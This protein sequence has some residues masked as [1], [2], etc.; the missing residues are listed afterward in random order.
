MLKEAITAIEMLATSHTRAPFVQSPGG[1]EFIFDDSENRYIEIKRPPVGMLVSGSLSSLGD[2]LAANIDKLETKDL[3]LHVAGPG[4][5]DL[6]GPLNEYGKRD[7]YVCSRTDSGNEGGKIEADVDPFIVSVL[8]TFEDTPAR[9]ALIDLVSSVKESETVQ[10][11]DDGLGQVVEAKK[12]MV[13]FK[14]K[15]QTNFELTPRRS[16]AEVANISSTWFLRVQ[17]GGRFILRELD[18]PE[19]RQKV[20]QAIKA[21]L[22]KQRKALKGEWAIVA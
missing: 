2:F 20:M 22:E 5:V 21:L 19:H 16:F 11:T 1:R 15:I 13:N 8:K 6:V 4:V 3:A 14:A 7:A 10:M 18:A 12:G 9:S 17:P